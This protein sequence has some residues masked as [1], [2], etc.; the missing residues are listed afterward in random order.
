MKYHKFW[1]QDFRNVTIDG[2]QEKIKIMA[3][4][5]V[6]KADAE[7]NLDAYTQIIQERINQGNNREEYEVEIKEHVTEI[8]N[9]KNI[10]TVNRYGALVWNTTQYTILDL[11]QFIEKQSIFDLFRKKPKVDKKQKILNNFKANVKSLSPLGNSFR[12]YETPNGIRI[13]GKNYLDPSHP[14]YNKIMATLQVD[15]LYAILSKK[16]NCYR[17]RLTPKPYRIPMQTIKIKSPLDC[18]TEAY[19]NWSKLYIEKS[20]NFSSV[21]L[22]ETI[23][24]DFSRDLIVQYHDKITQAKANYKLA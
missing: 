6:S 10:I 5:D 21:K 23:G 20:T 22:I 8:L 18:E 7:K 9:E 3:G 15:W 19:K 12:V 1:M 11:D 4:S 16:Q 14:E 2:K 13:I 17:A 24:E